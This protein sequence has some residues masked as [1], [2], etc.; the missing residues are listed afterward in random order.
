M[1]CDADP[2][3]AA[4]RGDAGDAVHPSP[5][6][7]ADHRLGHEIEGLGREDALAYYAR[8]YTPENAILIVAGDV[9]AEEARVLAEQHYGPIRPR[10][11]APERNR[12][13]EPDAGRAPPGRRQRREGRAAELA[14]LLSRALAPHRRARRIRGAR[15]ARPSP[16]RR[17]D[18]PALSQAGARGQEGASPPAPITWARRSTTRASS[19]TPCPPPASPCRISTPRSIARSPAFIAD[20]VDAAELERAKTRLVAEA[21]Y[22][23]DS[24]F[25]LARWYGAVARHRPDDPRRPGMAAAHRS[26][27]RRGRDRRGAQVARSRAAPSPAI[28]CRPNN[29]RR[30]EAA[31]PEPPPA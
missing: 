10:G 4:Q 14:A 9:D 8:F 27:A 2:E 1:H 7:H 31:D 19:S 29:R 15:G 6:R 25:A 21:I 18:Q 20:G 3:R 16:R 5:L 13:Q 28:C 22:A 23:Q 26:G 17:P 12:P 11:A 24:Q 30:P